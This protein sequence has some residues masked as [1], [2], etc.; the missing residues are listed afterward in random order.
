MKKRSKPRLNFRS[1]QKFPSYINFI[2]FDSA[3]RNGLLLDYPYGPPA[4]TKMLERT[5]EAQSQYYS[6]IR[7]INEQ[8]RMAEICAAMRRLKKHALQYADTLRTLDD[9]IR[10]KINAVQAPF[11]GWE[12][13]DGAQADADIIAGRADSYLKKWQKSKA[14]K[15]GGAPFDFP[16]YRYLIQ[17]I[18]IFE[19][20]NGRK[21]TL[22]KDAITLQSEEKFKG[23]FFS[24]VISFLEM[25]PG[26]PRRSRYAIGKAIE[27]A[28]VDYANIQDTE[29][30]IKKIEKLTAKEIAR[31][32]VV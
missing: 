14:R 10:E 31:Q 6:T 7:I 1:A 12:I 24:F 2:P 25:I 23:A 9:R 20:A 21:A 11:I 16:F 32:L 15:T 8:P 28:L 30:K 17:L 27:H 22:T 4:P 3:I 13:I 26:R 29:A 19:E 18:G 5:I